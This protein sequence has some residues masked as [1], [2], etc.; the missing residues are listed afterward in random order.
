MMAD[1]K[2]CPQSVAVDYSPKDELYLF[3]SDVGTHSLAVY[4]GAQDKYVSPK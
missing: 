1:N 4:N 2:S 3:V